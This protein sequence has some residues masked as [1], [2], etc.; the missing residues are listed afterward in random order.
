MLHAHF[1]APESGP[2]QATVVQ[3][4]GRRH[5]EGA[6]EVAD[7]G[8]LADDHPVLLLLDEVR[9]LRGQLEAREIEIVGLRT[10]LRLG[11]ARECDLIS[12]LHRNVLAE[13][14]KRERRRWWAPGGRFPRA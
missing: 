10:E 5:A 4:S 3:L 2:D 13:Q 6:G 1:A 8:L 7:A 9:R 14:A 12:V 11:Y